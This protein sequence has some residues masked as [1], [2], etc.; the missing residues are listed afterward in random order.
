MVLEYEQQHHPHRV[1]S[2]TIFNQL[3]TTI[4][5]NCGNVLHVV[6]ATCF[7]EC[8]ITFPAA[9]AHMQELRRIRSGKLGEHENMVTMHDIMD[10]QWLLDNHENES[11]LRSVVMPLERLLIGIKRC[12]VKDS[13][14]NSLCYGAQLMVPGLLHTASL[15][16]RD[17]HTVER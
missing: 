2:V 4:R 12:V 15:L 8:Y 1:A 9:G 17:V 11:Y 14:V 7:T 3:S 6:Y 5:G 16:P 10:A 13:T